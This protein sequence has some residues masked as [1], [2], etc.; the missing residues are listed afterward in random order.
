VFDSSSNLLVGQIPVGSGVVGVAVNP[1]Q[2]SIYLTS[3]ENGLSTIDATTGSV[4]ATTSLGGGFPVAVALSPDGAHA[5]V[6]NATGSVQVVDT[7]TNVVSANIPVAPLSPSSIAITP[8][9]AFAY[10]G[11]AQ[12]GS[13][14]ISLIDLS[15]NTVVGPINAGLNPVDIAVTPNGAFAYVV[16]DLAVGGNVTVLDTSTNTAVATIPVG[17][18]PSQLAVSPDGASVY[19]TNYASGTVSVIA[20]AS[21]TVVATI[22]VGAF[23]GSVAITPDGAFVYVGSG[24]AVAA[25]GTGSSLV[26]VIQASTN[27]VIAT[28]PSA[29]IIARLAIGSSP[30]TTQTITQPLSP[31]APNQF[32]FGTHNFNVQFPPGTTFSGVNMTVAAAQTTQTSFQQGVAGS[33]FPN[34]TCIVY[35]GSGGNCVNYQISCTDT[36]GNPIPCP[37]QPTASIAVKTSYDTVQSI[38]N[39]GF[40]HRPTGSTQWENIF[41]EFLAQRVDPTTKGKTKGFSDFVAVDLGA[42][43]TQ[44]S[45]T[46]QI[47]APL[48]PTDP[49]VFKRGSEINVRFQLKSIANPGE[50]ISDAQAGLSIVMIADAQGHAV[51]RERL[52]LPPPAFRYSS[53]RQSYY[54]ELEFENYAPGTYALTIYGNAFAVQQIL[55]TLK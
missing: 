47:G 5:Y 9:G 28:L 21:N 23:P 31:T 33:T 24:E 10:V 53:G 8:N 2:T 12:T 36:S 14:P 41:T 13:N 51:S 18:G 37:S 25:G 40:L 16:N 27:T 48:R 32:N 38:I 11:H 49:R 30:P 3:F 35:S 19:L 44:G 46:L 55:F 43:N 22:P 15:T 26:S 42:S 29:E 52:T 54:R 1:S 4:I 7:S 39:P 20:T 45:G 6:V 17:N 34:A 50:Y